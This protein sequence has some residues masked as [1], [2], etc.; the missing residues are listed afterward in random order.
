MFSQ[1]SPTLVQVITVGIGGAIGT[2]IPNLNFMIRSKP[3][4]TTL[5]KSMMQMQGH[6]KIDITTPAIAVRVKLGM[7]GTSIRNDINK[8]RNDL[9]RMQGVAAAHAK[10]SEE[11]LTELLQNGHAHSVRGRE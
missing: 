6:L 5:H 9:A 3:R 10:I 11:I 8:V 1:I 2:A 7:V 4:F